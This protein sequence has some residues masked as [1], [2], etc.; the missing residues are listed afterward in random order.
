MLFCHS[1]S[2]GQQHPILFWKLDRSSRLSHCQRLLDSIYS[3]FYTAVVKNCLK[4]LS[5]KNK[6]PKYF[7]GLNMC[8]DIIKFIDLYVIPVLAVYIV[9]ETKGKCISFCQ[10]YKKVNKC[11]IFSLCQKKKKDS[12]GELFLFFT[13]TEND[14]SVAA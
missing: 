11:I 14:A 2:Y 9:P 6:S 7:T 5:C 1:F 3:G 4:I 13:R 8:K 10:T 12:R